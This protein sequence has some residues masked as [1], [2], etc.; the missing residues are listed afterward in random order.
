MM[1][2]LLEGFSDWVMDRVGQEFIPDVADMRRRFEERRGRPRSTFDRIVS[3]VTGMDLKIEQ[4]RRGERFV[5]GV[6]AI[7]GR[8]A[9]DRLWDGPGS[10]PTETE[11]ADP[12]AWVRRVAGSGWADPPGAASDS[13][14]P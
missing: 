1:M 8:A 14:A 11:M 9:V 6:A 2:S 3:R 5:A 4:Y 12:A 10:I 13:D 7:G